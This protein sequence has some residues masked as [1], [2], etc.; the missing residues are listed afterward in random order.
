MNAKKYTRIEAEISLD[1]IHHN[2]DVMDA[3]TNGSSPICAVIKADGYGHGAVP[4]AREIE[5]RGD[6]WGFAV[7]T[8]EEGIE[9]RLAGIT[10]PVMLL[11]Y[12]FPESFESLIRL[13]IR[14]CVFDFETAQAVSDIAVKMNAAAKIHIALDTGMGRIGFEPTRD[15]AEVIRR[16]AELEGIVIEGIFSHFARCDEPSLDPARRQLKRYESFELLLE[17][18]GVMIDIHHLSNSAGIMRFAPAHK[19][20]VRA[21]ITLYGLMPSPEVADEMRE[22]IPAMRLI[23]HVSYVKTLPKGREISYGGTAVTKRDTVVATIPVGYADGYPRQ[24]S[25]RGCVLIGGKRAPILGRI[26]MD[27][28]MADVTDIPGVKRGDEVVLMGNAGSER[29]TAE[30]IGEI[31][32][33]FN[34][35]LV[36]N[37]TKRV[38]RTYVKGGRITEQL[39]YFPDIC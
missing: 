31:S 19:D 10:K 8:A 32:G 7:A 29:I 5:G 26:C 33:R 34:Y 1:A 15:S 36:C 24:L 13:D 35:E 25:N 28:F 21:G 17:E 20:L 11:G 4:I 30:E 14:L 38:P 6:I 22:L 9:L 18:A 16:I 2:L 27:Q 37:V 12:A 39:D 3:R 23:S